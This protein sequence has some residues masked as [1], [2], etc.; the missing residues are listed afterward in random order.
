M[1]WYEKFKSSLENNSCDSDNSS[2]LKLKSSLC[3]IG[4]QKSENKYFGSLYFISFYFSKDISP[5][6]S[7][8]VSLL[9]MKIEFLFFI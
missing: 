9:I 4:K 5:V 1:F 6:D 8:S 2:D 3:F 7:L